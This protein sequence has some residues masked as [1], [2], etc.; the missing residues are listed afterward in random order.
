MPIMTKLISSKA[1]PW[2]VII[3]MLLPCACME[4]GLW[5][6][7]AANQQNEPPPPPVDRSAKLVARYTFEN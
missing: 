1:L 3:A 7:P 6:D 5:D 4:M 2:S